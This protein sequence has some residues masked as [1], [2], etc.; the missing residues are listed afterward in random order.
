MSGLFAGVGLR[1]FG[2]N[3]SLKNFLLIV[4]V[5]GISWEVLEIGTGAVELFDQA[6]FIDTIKDLIDDLL[7]A[8]VAYL[9]WRKL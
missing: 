3:E 9:I 2:F 1:F 7:G 8:G 5:I 4:L 6:Y